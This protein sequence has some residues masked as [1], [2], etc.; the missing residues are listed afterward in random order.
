MLEE[1]RREEEQERHTLRKTH[2]DTAW[3]A[4]RKINN[5]VRVLGSP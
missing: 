3:P 4:V 5:E 2:R 1:G